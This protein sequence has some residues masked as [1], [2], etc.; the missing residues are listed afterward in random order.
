MGGPPR[1]L[2]CCVRPLDRGDDIAPDADDVAIAIRA[3]VW[4]EGGELFAIEPE[5]TDLAFE[6]LNT[7]QA[8][9]F[10]LEE[11]EPLEE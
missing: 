7:K 5:S 9:D 10:K 8:K 3:A 1:H 2:P 4:Q 11:Y 6:V